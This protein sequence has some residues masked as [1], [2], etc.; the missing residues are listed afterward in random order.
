MENTTQRRPSQHCSSSRKASGR[1]PAW[2]RC[3]LSGRQAVVLF[4]VGSVLTMSSVLS[5]YGKLRAKAPNVASE[6]SVSGGSVMSPY[7]C[8]YAVLCRYNAATTGGRRRATRSRSL[9]TF[10]FRSEG[11]R[12]RAC[13]SGNVP[14]LDSIGGSPRLHRS[15]LV[16][17]QEAHAAS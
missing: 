13:R 17:H 14:S 9:Y 10:E 5:G 15:L 6:N 3:I 11:I 2:S 7:R 16:I 1:R 8:L 12:R 4:H